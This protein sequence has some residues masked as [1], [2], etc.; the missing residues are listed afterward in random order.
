MTHEIEPKLPQNDHENSSGELVSQEWAIEAFITEVTDKKQRYIVTK[1]LSGKET[2]YDR[3]Y[4]PLRSPTAGFILSPDNLID[5]PYRALIGDHEHRS[6]QEDNGYND[7]VLLANHTTLQVGDKVNITRWGYKQPSN[8]PNSWT[9]SYFENVTVLETGV[10]ILEEETRTLERKQFIRKNLAAIIRRL[11]QLELNHHDR[12]VTDAGAVIS[13]N[14]DDQTGISRAEYTY[15]ESP[16]EDHFVNVMAR[17]YSSN[18]DADLGGDTRY[19][20]SGKA[21]VARNITPASPSSELALLNEPMVELSAHVWT[22]TA[23][24]PEVDSITVGFIIDGVHYSGVKDVELS[25]HYFEEPGHD[26]NFNSFLVPNEEYDGVAVLPEELDALG[27]YHSIKHEVT[28]QRVYS[29]LDERIAHKAIRGTA[30]TDIETIRSRAQALEII[31]QDALQELQPVINGIKTRPSD[32]KL[33][34]GGRLL[35]PASK[36]V[37]IEVIVSRKP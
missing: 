18:D 20:H 13:W 36:L 35:V 32:T 30:S 7:D 14:H 27:K 2:L 10:D 23:L 34:L 22:E 5:S 8:H 12:L 28:M 17:P 19:T 29:D 26:L 24:N 37:S 33:G 15:G 21:F 9:T 31:R 6:I 1:V 11:E 25:S 3:S 4:Q 16:V